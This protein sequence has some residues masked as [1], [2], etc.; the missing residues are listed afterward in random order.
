LLLNKRL[1]KI[2]GKVPKLKFKKYTIY[3][4]FD[5]IFSLMMTNWAEKAMAR[6]AETYIK[7]PLPEEEPANVCSCTAGPIKTLGQPTGYL[8]PQPKTRIISQKQKP[9][10]LTS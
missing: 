1:Q 8:S 9:I 7:R 4:V 3:N 6:T 5:N 10:A 2:Q